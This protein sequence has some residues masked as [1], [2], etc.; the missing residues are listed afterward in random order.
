M[1]VIR[2]A[3]GGSERACAADCDAWNVPPRHEGI[4]LPSKPAGRP[5][6]AAQPTRGGA[7]GGLCRR[8]VGGV[9]MGGGDVGSVGRCRSRL[10]ARDERVVGSA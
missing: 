2:I 8:Q 6:E 1:S 4:V 3:F 7:H 10:R 9:S 5:K